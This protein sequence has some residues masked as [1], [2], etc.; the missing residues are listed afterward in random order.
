MTK[1]NQNDDAPARSLAQWLDYLESVHPTTIDM[2]LERVQRVATRLAF[3]FSSQLVITVA[4]TNGKG[5]TCRFLEQALLSQGK[6]TGVYSSPH[7]I[8][9]RERVRLNGELQ[10]EPE[11][12]R[13]LEAVE[14]ARGEISLTYFEFGTLAA[15]Y[16]FSQWQVDAIILEVGLGGRLDATNIVDPNIAVITTIDLDHQDWL[17]NTREKIAL[18][19]AGIFRDHGSA[20]VGELFPPRTL[21]AEAERRNVN[22]WWA[23]QHFEFMPGDKTWAWRGQASQFTQLPVPRIPMQNVS[24]ALAVLEKLDLLPS[25]DSVRQIIQQTDMPGRQQILSDTPQIVLDVAHNPQATRAMASWIGQKDYRQLYFVVGMLKDKA[26]NETLAPLTAISAN[27]YVADTKGPRGCKADVLA[28]ALSANDIHQSRLFNCVE[29]AFTRAKAAAG[30]DDL[31]V[32]FG[33]FL[34]VADV[35]ATQSQSE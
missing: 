29:E 5:T 26:I 24:T 16:M 15:L 19:K 3:D 25:Q 18:E 28:A 14:Q 11:Y 13:A 8:D 2:G 30:D 20:V 4:G 34:T 21:M 17:G 32:V 35:L 10:P 1:T 27:W 7:L 31:I 9:Y 22:T 6:T 33:S 12:C 23:S